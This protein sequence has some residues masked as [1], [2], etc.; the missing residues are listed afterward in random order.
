MAAVLGGKRSKKRAAFH[1]LLSVTAL[2]FFYPMIWMVMSSFKTNRKIFSEPFALPE[3]LNFGRW[4]EAWQSG[5]LSRYAFNSVIVTSVTVLFVLFFASM[6]AYAFSKWRFKGGKLLLS[7]FIA[8]LF[9]PVQSYFIAQNEL[10][11]FLKLRDTHW[12]LIVPYIAIGLPLAIFLLK[13]YI[14]TIPGEMTDSAR[15]DGCKEWQIYSRIIIPVIL[16]GLATVAIFTS[17]NAWNEFLLAILYIQDNA[18]KTI[19]AGL[20]TFS[21]RYVTDYSK[22]FSALSLV[23]IPMIAVY[24]LFSRHIIAGLTEGAIK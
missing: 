22:L 12:A 20:L 8:G 11:A 10:V 17:L 2:W 21:S 4:A 1:L 14:D 3:S 16:P 9:L 5:H 15:M 19:P 24:V 13:A 7:L 6:A 18:Y 23:T